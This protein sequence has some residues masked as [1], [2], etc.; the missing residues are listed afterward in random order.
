MPNEV[1]K[2]ADILPIP[3][4]LKPFLVVIIIAPEPARIPYNAVA[5]APLR[6]FIDS[7]SS[8]LISTARFEYA[9]PPVLSSVDNIE[10]SIGIPSITNNG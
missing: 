9:T 2:D 3:F 10:L 1:E 8:G 4:S 5:A 6:T 7:I